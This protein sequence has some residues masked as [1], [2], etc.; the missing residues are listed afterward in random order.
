MLSRLRLFTLLALAI[1]THAQQP[2]AC[3]SACSQAQSCEILGTRTYTCTY[4]LAGSSAGFYPPTEATSISVRATSGHG[5]STSDGLGGSGATIEATWL[6]PTTYPPVMILYPGGTASVSY[7]GELSQPF[8]LDAVK[9]NKRRPDPN[10]EG[11]AGASNRVPGGKGGAFTGLSGESGS[12][13]G[14]ASLLTLPFDGFR[15]HF[16]L[17]LCVERFPAH[18][19][20][21]S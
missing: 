12:G 18:S 19:L 13:G 1:A 3:P 20:A 17:W 10:I 9:A 11:D 5:G 7:P 15:T 4:N 8:D 21:N 6:D 16:P 2:V 14:A